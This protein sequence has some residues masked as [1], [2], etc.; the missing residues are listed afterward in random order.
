MLS[1]S[2]LLSRNSWARK[3]KSLRGPSSRRIRRWRR[4]IGIS[5]PISN[6]LWLEQWRSTYLAMLFWMQPFRFCSKCPWLSQVIWNNWGSLALE[7]SG[8]LIKVNRT[9][10]SKRHL[11]TWVMLAGHSTSIALSI[12]RTAFELKTAPISYWMRELSTSK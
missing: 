11:N 2:L 6:G 3:G 10:K 4:R 1:K 12:I 5:W 7:R 8:N 9:T